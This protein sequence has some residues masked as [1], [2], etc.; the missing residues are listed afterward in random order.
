[1]HSDLASILRNGGYSKF[2]SIEMKNL[3]DIEM[4]KQTAENVRRIFS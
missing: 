3:G 1:L 4:V 2:V